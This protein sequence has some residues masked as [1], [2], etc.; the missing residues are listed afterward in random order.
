[1]G[2]TCATAQMAR[3]T[4]LLQSLKACE[5][6]HC[7]F[8]C[9]H[10]HMHV[11]VC[12]CVHACVGVCMH[13]CACMHTCVCVHVY[14]CVCVYVCVHTLTGMTF[15]LPTFQKLMMTG[16]LGL[17]SPLYAV[18]CF[19]SFTSMSCRPHISNWNPPK[20]HLKTKPQSRSSIIPNKGNS[21]S[22][23]PTLRHPNH[24]SPQKREIWQCCITPTPWKEKRSLTV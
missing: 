16:W 3:Q 10:A 21:P 15:P 23:P 2:R 9:V 24:P 22:P 14:V 19:Q 13:V 17:Y 7:V 1:M 6:V 5:G 18:C 12:V 8:V 4:N 20:A 11:C